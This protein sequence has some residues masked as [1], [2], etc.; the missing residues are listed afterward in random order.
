MIGASIVSAATAT[1][2]GASGVKRQPWANAPFIPGPLSDYMRTQFA[3]FN[4]AD[5]YR[6]RFIRMSLTEAIQR[7]DESIEAVEVPQDLYSPAD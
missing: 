3:F 6:P 7:Y 5:T 2:V 1:E 4:N